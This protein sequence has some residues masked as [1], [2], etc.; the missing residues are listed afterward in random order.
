M[1]EWW[2]FLYALG[3]SLDKIASVME[4]GWSVYSAGLTNGLDALCLPIFA[5][6]F[7]F[8]FH[9]IIYND[10][11][12]ADQCFAVL[13]VAACFLF[14]RLVFA[15]MTNNVMILSLRAM[16]GQFLFLMAIA[17]FCFGGFV[18][19]LN[20]LCDGDFSVARI[21][22]WLVFIWFGL[23]GSGIDA[24]PTFHKL[25]GPL[26]FVVYAALSNTLLVSLLVAI[27]SDTYSKIASDEIA[28]DMFRKAV[29]TFEG[30]KADSLF[31]YLPPINL[32]ALTVMWPV[33]YVT[34][35]RWFHKISKPHSIHRAIPRHVADL[36]S[37]LKQTSPRRGPSRSRSCS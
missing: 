14:P 17:V 26:L 27:L 5:T 32:L 15:T 11:W 30:V 33:S 37:S 9:S 8:R 24:S 25:L 36:A 1:H 3:Y 6:A 13:S 10:P 23:D 2:F 12:S 22:E 31:D 35:P 18:F 20:H 7:G 21:S 34:N 29:M 4:H 16:L 19:A 28:E